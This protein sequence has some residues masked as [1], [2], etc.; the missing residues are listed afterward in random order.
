[1][2]ILEAYDLVGSFRAAAEI[3]GCDHHTVKLHV[4]RRAAGLATW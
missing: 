2:N 4:E 3:A 1:M